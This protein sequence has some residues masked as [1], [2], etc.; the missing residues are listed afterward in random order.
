MRT[1]T[2]IICI[3]FIFG[4]TLGKILNENKEK[5]QR[6]AAKQQELY[7]LEQQRVDLEKEK[8]RLLFELNTKQMT[9]DELFADLEKLEKEN[10][11]LLVE[12]EKMRIQKQNFEQHIR[13]YKEEITELQGDQPVS[14]EDKARRIE[15][16]KEEI[17]KYLKFSLGKK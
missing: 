11:S 7:D 14:S 13:H 12:S 9:L 4:C 5:E 17:I 2:F 8:E 3:F 15:K 10:A 1:F 16:L 6:I